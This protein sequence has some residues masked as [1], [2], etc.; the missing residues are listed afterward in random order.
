MKW[1]SETRPPHTSQPHNS[2]LRLRAPIHAENTWNNQMCTCSLSFL[3][4]YSSTH[5]HTHTRARTHTSER[6]HTS[7]ARHSCHVILLGIMPTAKHVTYQKSPRQSEREG[8]RLCTLVSL[9]EL[10]LVGRKYS[11][12]T[13]NMRFGCCSCQLC[14]VWGQWI[15]RKGGTRDLW[16][17]MW[18]CSEEHAM[19]TVHCLNSWKASWKARSQ[20][21]SNQTSYTFRFQM[22]DPLFSHICSLHRFF[23]SLCT[24]LCLSWYINGL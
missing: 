7:Q 6:T 22:A 21:S 15:L 3:F 2:A 11:T 9:W 23:F 1:L 16:D 20:P 12:H 5:V 24:F 18:N 19:F 13:C 14:S 4:F 17:V 10:L 8:E